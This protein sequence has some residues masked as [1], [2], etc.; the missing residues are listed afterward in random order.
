M[1]VLEEV[2][3]NNDIE[4]SSYKFDCDDIVEMTLHIHLMGHKHQES[5]YDTSVIKSTEH[6]CPESGEYAELVDKYGMDAAKRNGWL[7]K[8]KKL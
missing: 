3:T 4:L 2:N 6:K 8:D 7:E 5:V 1:V